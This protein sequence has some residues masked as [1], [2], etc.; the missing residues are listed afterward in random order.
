MLAALESTPYQKRVRAAGEAAPHK[1]FKT[2]LIPH[3]KRL[4]SF[5]KTVVSYSVF[6]LLVTVVKWL[7][8]GKA[9]TR[10][11]EGPSTRTK[12]IRPLG[13]VGSTVWKLATWSNY[14]LS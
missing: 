1:A 6:T 7:R 3:E 13:N 8:E 4:C 14:R 2:T 12:R 5:E 10:A 11:G 9:E